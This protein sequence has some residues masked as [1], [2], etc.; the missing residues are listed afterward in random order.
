MTLTW[1]G[2]NWLNQVSK[3]QNLDGYDFA[4]WEVEHSM[5]MKTTTKGVSIFN[6][7]LIGPRAI[8]GPSFCYCSI[9]RTMGIVGSQLSTANIRNM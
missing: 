6:F 3:Q 7:Q 5:C 2:P 1:W 4:D 9:M 8:M